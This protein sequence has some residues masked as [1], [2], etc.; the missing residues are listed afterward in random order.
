MPKPSRIGHRLWGQWLLWAGLG[1]RLWGGKLHF[2]GQTGTQVTVYG[3]KFLGDPINGN[4]KV[5]SQDLK[6]SR[7]CRFSAG[8]AGARAS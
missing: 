3:V 6:N 8:A 7:L 1:H 2:G 4:L 5:R